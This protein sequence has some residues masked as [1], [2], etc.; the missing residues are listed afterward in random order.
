ML[1]I[2]TNSTYRLH[3]LGGTSHELA[4]QNDGRSASAE[5][6]GCGHDQ[7]KKLLNQRTK[8][9]RLGVL[10]QANLHIHT[11]SPT[12]ER[13]YTPGWTADI[14]LSLTYQNSN[15]LRLHQV[16]IQS[17]RAPL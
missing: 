2:E 4:I 13:I 6:S 1:L 9:T 17:F 15:G 16:Q 10:N 12:L 3:K 8:Q 7:P 14:I 11:R 5:T